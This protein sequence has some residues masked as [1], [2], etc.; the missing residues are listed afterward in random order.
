MLTY[1]KEAL[2]DVY[3]RRQALGAFTVYNIE[4]AAFSAKGIAAAD[5]VAAKL[6]LFT[7]HHNGSELP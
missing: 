1:G 6:R 4:L 5:V 7:R 3:R 2:L